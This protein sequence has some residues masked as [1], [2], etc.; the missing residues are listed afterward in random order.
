M[1]SSA[2][3]TQ[4][5]AACLHAER[6]PQRNWHR[7]QAEVNAASQPLSKGRIIQISWPQRCHLALLPPAVYPRWP[8]PPPPPPPPPPPRPSLSTVYFI[9]PSIHKTPDRRLLRC[10]S[11]PCWQPHCHLKEVWATQVKN[12]QF[13]IRMKQNNVICKGLG[14]LHSWYF[15]LPTLP[16]T[17]SASFCTFMQCFIQCAPTFDLHTIN[18]LNSWME[19]NFI[20]EKPWHNDYGCQ[21]NALIWLINYA[22]INA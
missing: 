9:W 12:I 19:F 2:E 11:D 13:K 21:C 1:P 17:A 7:I 5:Q 22:L 15:V 3:V 4:L 20:W 8:S 10:C 6:E 16:I 14:P 18:I